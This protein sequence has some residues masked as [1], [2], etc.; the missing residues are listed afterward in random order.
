M[1]ACQ[2]LSV[3][4]LSVSVC[5]TEIDLSQKAAFMAEFALK[6]ILA[7]QEQAT[8]LLATGNSQ[9][10]FL[11][12]LTA[13]KALDWNRL[14]CWH[15]DEFLGVAPDFPGSFRYYLHERVEK[16]VC[17]G[18]FHYIRGDAAEPLKE[19][20]RYTQLLLSRSID[21]CCLGIGS[22]GHLAFNEPNVADFDDPDWVKLVK[23]DASTRAAQIN[24]AYF[25]DLES[26]PQY[27]F[28]VT[29]P[30]IF[31]SRQII[32]LSPGAAKAS[33]VKTLLEEAVTPTCPASILRHHPNATL[34]LDQGSAC[35]LSSLRSEGAI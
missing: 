3:D 24:P 11:E 8:I 16:R 23:L 6:Q 7:S 19:C 5:D 25:R 20:D 31:S 9:I 13:S 15:L 35:L 14:I 17:P 12:Q 28:T 1:F 34:W 18:E 4:H 21:L 29:I 2:H 26:V 30:L 32:C 33:I 27:A 22:N 10:L